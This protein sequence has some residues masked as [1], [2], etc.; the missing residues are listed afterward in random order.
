MHDVNVG[1]FTVRNGEQWSGYVFLADHHLSVQATSNDPPAER[2][3]QMGAAAGDC[4]E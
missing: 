2:P 4:S 3:P 1:E